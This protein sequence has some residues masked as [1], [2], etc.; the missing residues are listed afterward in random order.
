MYICMFMGTVDDRYFVQMYVCFALYRR[1]VVQVG[2]WE[3]PGG[4]KTWVMMLMTTDHSVH[5]V[6]RYN[7]H[8]HVH[9]CTLYIF[10]FL[11][12]LTVVLL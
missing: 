7:V 8:V 5:A 11:P 2:M 6:K 9:V 10:N 12:V 1:R 3:W 4:H